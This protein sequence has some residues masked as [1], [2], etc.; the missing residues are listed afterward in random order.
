M[1]MLFFG[2]FG[3][4]KEVPKKLYYSSKNYIKFTTLELECLTC[5]IIFGVL[6][7]SHA[8]QT[9]SISLPRPA[10]P[11]RQPD[12]INC[13]HRACM[14]RDHTVFGDSCKIENDTD[15]R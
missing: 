2:V 14:K 10:S 15:C 3:A 6:L 13:E 8:K 4:A 7:W 12:V 1:T 9:L 11:I 5:S